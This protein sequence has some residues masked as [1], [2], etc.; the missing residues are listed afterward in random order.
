MNIC[1]RE[2][3]VAYRLHLRDELPEQE[4]LKAMG[5]RRVTSNPASDQGIIVVDVIKSSDETGLAQ[6]VDR[7]L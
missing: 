5:R 3:D 6:S 7:R 2:T 1:A 4:S